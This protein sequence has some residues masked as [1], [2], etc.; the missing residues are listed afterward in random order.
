MRTSILWAKVNEDASGDISALQWQIQQLKGQ[1]SFLT[2]N[3]VFPPLVSNLEPNFDSCRLSEASEE[4]DSMGERTTADGKLHTPNKEIKRMKAA[5]VGALRREKMAETTIQNLNIEIDRMKCLAQQKEEDAQH[6]S[7]MLSH[8]E[9]KIK[10]LEL[11]V[12]GQ[13]SAEKHLMEENKALKEEFRLQLSACLEARSEESQNVE[14]NNNNNNDDLG[15]LILQLLID[16]ISRPAPN[17]THLLLKFDLDT[18]VERTILQ[19]KFYYSCMKVILDILEKLLK[20]DVNAL[21]HEFSFQESNPG[22]SAQV[23]SNNT[24]LG[25]ES[26]A[27]AIFTNGTV[28]CPIDEGTFLSVDLHLLE[29]I[30]LK[31][32]TKHI[33]EIIKQ[34]LNT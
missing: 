10:Q 21:L 34:S 7:I 23:W 17:I 27:N 26:G 15:I 20:P 8:C 14:N 11:L 30:E 24:T 1:L 12:D 4:H 28:T 3:K 16:N 31:K 2:K 6:T 5:L 19:P 18:P 32:R 22:H 25:S 13:L 33:V 29:S 9:E